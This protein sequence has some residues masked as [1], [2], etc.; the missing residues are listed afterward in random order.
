MTSRLPCAELLL[1]LHAAVACSRVSIACIAFCALLFGRGGQRR[2]FLLD[3]SSASSAASPASSRSCRAE[4]L[5]LL[6]KQRLRR[7]TARRRL[8]QRLR[9][10]EGDLDGVP[11][12]RCADTGH[13]RENERDRRRAK[14]GTHENS[15]LED[16]TELEVDL[17]PGILVTRS[18][19]VRSNP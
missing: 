16:L 14:H 4:A 2:L 9:I 17:P 1:E 7:R 3:I 6:G 18:A 11:P 12:A 8:H 10:D 13:D 19:S 5:A 15:E